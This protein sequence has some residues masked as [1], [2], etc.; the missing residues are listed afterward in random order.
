VSSSKRTD[1]RRTRQPAFLVAVSAW[2]VARAFGA[3]GA[4]PPKSV[5]VEAVLPKKGSIPTTIVLPAQIAPEQGAVL[6][7]KVA[8]YLK[9]ITVDKGDKVKAG[10]LIAELEVPELLADRMQFK[11]Q[12]DVTRVD[13][14]R[15]RD[16]IKSAPDLVTPQTVDDAHGKLDV[17]QAQL[18]RV[19]TLLRYARITAPFA[20]TITARYAD[21]GAFIPVATSNS[22]ENAAVVNLM[23]FSRVRVQVFVPEAEASTVT[24]GTQAVVTAKGLPGQQFTASVTRISYALDQSARTML[25]EIEM[26]NPNE[27][28]RP[29]MYASVE[30]TL[31]SPG[32]ALLVPSSAIVSEGGNSALYIVVNGR[33]VKKPVTVGRK[34]DDTAEID[35]GLSADQLVILPGKQTLT[36]GSSLAVT[37]K[38]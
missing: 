21:P 11:A 5:A 12:R 29:G 9:R 16:A 13:Y 35:S 24:T 4:P 33:A 15:M 32:Q 27:V 37:V 2:A 3:D 20:G 23:D 26:N 19:E 25:A 17:A 34:N 30:L 36:D 7:A 31:S 18:D 28:L 8:G 22:Q 1:R 38:R 14:E 10:A 6:T